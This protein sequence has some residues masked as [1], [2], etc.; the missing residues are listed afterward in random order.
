ME[1]NEIGIPVHIINQII[2]VY[3]KSDELKKVLNK[4]PTNEEIA[5]SLGWPDKRA[6][7]L[8]EAANEIMNK[9]NFS[10]NELDY[11]KTLVGEQDGV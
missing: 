6:K 11:F 2:K 10:G 7:G 1:N 4:Q 8:L 5:K 9:T 3:E